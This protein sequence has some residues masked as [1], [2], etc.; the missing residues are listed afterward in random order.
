MSLYFKEQIASQLGE[1]KAPNSDLK[2]DVF[3][4]S[5]AH[6]PQCSMLYIKMHLPLLHLS[7]H[8]TSGGYQ[9]CKP[10]QGGVPSGKSLTCGQAAKTSVKWN[11]LQN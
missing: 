1:G 10:G 4:Q 5:Q 7:L 11:H 2:K 8:V 6:S 9:V 3:P